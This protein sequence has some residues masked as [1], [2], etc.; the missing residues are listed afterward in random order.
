MA[1]AKS[2]SLLRKLRKIC[3]AL[4]ECLNLVPHDALETLRG[5]TVP[6]VVATRTV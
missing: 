1:K 4:P 6:P 5:T 3:L 2:G